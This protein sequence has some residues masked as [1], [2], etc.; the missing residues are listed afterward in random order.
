M[1]KMTLV[2]LLASLGAMTPAG[3]AAE[4]SKEGPAGIRNVVLVH[5]AFADA[6]GWRGVYDRL[7]A[8]GYH[9]AMVQEPETS[10]AA[11]VAATE[12]VLDMQDGPTLLVG[13]SWGGQ[14]ITVAGRH[15]KVKALVY[16]AALMP[17]VGES[18][19]A[20]EAPR[21]AAGAPATK[22]PD[23]YF[24]FPVDKFAQD[25]AGDLPK[26]QAEFMAR[27]QVLISGEALDAPATVAAWKD[28]PSW[29]IVAAADRVINPEL[30]RWMYNRG[31]AK[32]TE[33]AGAAH[34]V[35]ISHPDVVAEVIERAAA[36][37]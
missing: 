26:A 13:H 34:T 21:P 32:V 12:R 27:S 29:A 8:K 14:V 9:V 7:V 11:D 28:K 22:L 4:S 20:L 23:G 24:M 2:S 19:S 5:G 6:S 16:V 35:F 33:V 1:M 15:A 25:F 30:E 10:L 31:K 36:V 3:A 18:T 37:K 17:D